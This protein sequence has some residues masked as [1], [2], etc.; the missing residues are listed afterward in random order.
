MAGAGRKDT[1]KVQREK[2][3]D[4]EYPGKRRKQKRRQSRKI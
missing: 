4:G 3:R 2:R 1:E